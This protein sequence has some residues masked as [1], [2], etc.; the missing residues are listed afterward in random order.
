MK[1]RQTTYGMRRNRRKMFHRIGTVHPIVA[2]AAVTLLIFAAWRL[3][4]ADGRHPQLSA[5]NSLELLKVGTDGTQA[6]QIVEIGRAH[7]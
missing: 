4:A 6:E 3:T 2:L 7:V 5:G 1:K